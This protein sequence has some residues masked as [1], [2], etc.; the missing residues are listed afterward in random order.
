MLCNGAEAFDHQ[1]EFFAG[2]D[3]GGC[4][5]S[6]VGDAGFDFVGDQTPVEGEGALPGFEGGVEWFAETAGPHL[7]WII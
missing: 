1:G 4:D 7:Y 6:G 2:E 3:A 5:G